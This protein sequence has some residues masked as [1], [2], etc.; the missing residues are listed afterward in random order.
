MKFTVELGSLK[1]SGSSLADA[2]AITDSWPATTSGQATIAFDI[3]DFTEDERVNLAAL[4]QKV[5]VHL[6][7]ILGHPAGQPIDRPVWR[8]FWRNA[9]DRTHG[10]GVSFDVF[11][12]QYFAQH[13]LHTVLTMTEG[14]AAFH[15]SFESLNALAAAGG[16]L[17]NLASW[18]K[19]W[20]R[21]VKLMSSTPIKWG[22]FDDITLYGKMG[23]KK[24]VRR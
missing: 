6:R 22:T 20:T 17:F 12:A 18:P 15:G 2:L 13:G 4:I 24:L 21:E 11:C 19:R 10:E 1:H 5:S 7:F 8:K 9:I 23:V 3:S 14:C 16:R